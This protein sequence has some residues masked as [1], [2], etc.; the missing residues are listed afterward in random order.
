[1]KFVLLAL[2][3]ASS[4][5]ASYGVDVYSALSVDTMVCLCEKGFSNFFIFRAWRSVGKFDTAAPTNY[6]NAK[7]TGWSTKN[8]YAY[9]YPCYSCGNAG[10][11]VS[12]FWSEV[13]SNNME[14]GKVFFD[15]E[16]SWSSSTSSNKKF[17]EA[18][19]TKQRELGFSAGIY[20]SY[21]QWENIFGLSYK[22]QYASEYPM[23][24]AHYDNV[25]SFSDFDA[26]G[27]WSSPYMKQYAGDVTACSTDVDYNYRA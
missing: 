16:G 20:S 5:A 19:I 12:T 1:M 23:W 9:F 22:F 26:F 13:Q 18:L 24:Y 8:L 15:I 21:Y 6:K 17:F 14:L 27:G 3:V 25:K 4:L 7:E 2:F 11:Q 10:G